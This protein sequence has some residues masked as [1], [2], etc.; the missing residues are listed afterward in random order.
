LGA[1]LDAVVHGL[2]TL[3]TVTD[4]EWPRMADFAMWA[5][6]CEGAYAKPGTFKTAYAGNR[7]D[8]ISAMI[9]GDVVASAVLRLA[10]P[11]SGQLATLLEKLTAVVGDVHARARPW[12]KSPRGLGSALRRAAPLLTEQGVTVA[13]PPPKDKTRTWK[14]RQQ[15]PEQPEQPSPADFANKS[16]DLGSDDRP[17]CCRIEGPQQPDLQ[18][19]G[20]PRKTNGS[21][22]LGDL[23]CSA[24]HYSEAGGRGDAADG[25]P[26]AP[27]PWRGRI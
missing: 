24:P 20:K 7:A 27:N 11:W 13:P 4:V 19:A 14:I 6:A 12:P 10:L 3:P 16:S 25:P 1:L 23:G 22:D 8:A 17:G 15:Q 18:P 5:T 2:R 9:E 26:P 21:G